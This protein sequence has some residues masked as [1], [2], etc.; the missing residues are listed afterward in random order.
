MDRIREQ[1]K[2]L[3]TK[4]LSI[5]AFLLLLLASTLLINR[6]GVSKNSEAYV[7]EN[8]SYCGID[9]SNWYIEYTIAVA[10]KLLITISRFS[11]YK[12]SRKENIP[13]YLFDLI[14]MNILM[15]VVFI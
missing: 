5:S 11:Y 9:L 15:T 10:L 3:K 12:R 1:Q 13:L 2:H 4:I 14:V 6:I 8:D 7:S